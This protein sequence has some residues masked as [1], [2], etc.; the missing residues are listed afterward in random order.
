MRT[1]TPWTRRWWV[2]PEMK[3]Q[4][5]VEV[6]AECAP[7]MPSNCSTSGAASAAGWKSSAVRSNQPTHAMRTP[8]IAGS[9]TRPSERPRRATPLSPP[10]C[11]LCAAS[12]SSYRSSSHSTASATPRMTTMSSGRLDTRM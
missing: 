5:E 4:S 7:T 10:R 3:M 6:H 11:G 8:M 1:Y 12:S 9:S 2:E